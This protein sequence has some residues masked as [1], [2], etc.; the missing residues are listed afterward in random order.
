VS[1][2]TPP[3][4]AP[5]WDGAWDAVTGLTQ[6]WLL[7]AMNRTVAA[8]PRLH[9]WRLGDDK[10][11]GR[12]VQWSAQADAELSRPV[13]AVLAVTQRD[14]DLPTGEDDDAY[15]AGFSA[16][17]AVV[18][19][20]SAAAHDAAAKAAP[21]PRWVGVLARLEGSWL[22]AMAV[23]PAQLSDVDDPGT[24]WSTESVDFDRAH[25]VH[26]ADVEYAAA[27]LAPHVMAVVMDVLPRGAAVTVAGD[28]L[29]VWWPYRP[30]YD[31]E[32]SRVARGAAA[33]ARLA[34]AIPSFVLADHPDH[35]DEVE[36]R[37]A[38]REEAAL[39]YREQRR[40]GYSPDPVLQRIY[41][42]ARH[43]AGLPD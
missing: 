31:A 2:Q 7:A 5:C 22:P 24:G 41:S 29:H 19:V 4:P 42:A 30:P 25:R 32:P 39:A 23:L 6:L 13:Y 36:G 14:P 9:P 38:E 1:S 20:L 43:E 12:L 17:D 16:M 3:D 10:G 28:A 37:L 33:V 18:D 8:L 26:A 35:S 34:D 21:A 27:V 11:T 40:P 15:A